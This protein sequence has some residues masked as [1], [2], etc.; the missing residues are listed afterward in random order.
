MSL[1]ASGRVATT[2]NGSNTA[3]NSRHA[4]MK[5][6]NIH[7]TINKAA[8]NKQAVTELER[9]LERLMHEREELGRDLASVK[10]R[11]KVHET[12]ELASEEDTLMANL[13]YIQESILQAQ[14]S[15]M[16]L[17]EGKESVSEQSA[18]Q[19][20]LDSVKSVDEAKYLLERLFAEC[21]T[22][23]CEYGL[24]QARLKEREA[25]LNEVQQDSNIQQQLLQ[26]VLSE[27]P[28][29]ISI[30]SSAGAGEELIDLNS[31]LPD[32]MSSSYPGIV[33]KSYITSNRSNHSSRSTSPNPSER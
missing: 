12:S 2:A 19:T 3:Y 1:K 30:A 23:A 11:Q 9:E 32:S 28:N 16:E 10:R 5:W 17:E 8:R 20:A 4:K 7:R 25:L 21:I 31:L 24:S 15:I 6:F 27:N 22:N 13:N 18:L 26:H 14:H 29:T 33:N